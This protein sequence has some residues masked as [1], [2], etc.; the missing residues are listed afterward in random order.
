M[1]NKLRSEEHKPKL[2]IYQEKDEGLQFIIKE[3]FNMTRKLPFAC[4]SSREIHPPIDSGRH[5]NLL[6]ET[7]SNTSCD[8]L[9]FRSVAQERHRQPTNH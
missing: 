7:F 2:S 4:N 5:F 6:L 1:R 8:H 9:H 3:I